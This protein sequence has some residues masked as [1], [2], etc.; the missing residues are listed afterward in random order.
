MDINVT[1]TAPDLSG[2]I[3]SLAD[4]IVAAG[5][6]PVHTGLLES[7][8]PNVA[9]IPQIELP[10]IPAL[11]TASAPVQN[12]AQPQQLMQP[13]ITPPVQI[14][15]QQFVQ[16]PVIPAQI[17]VQ[18]QPQQPP[19]TPPVVPTAPSTY[20]MEQLAVAATQLMD[21][22]RKNDLLNLLAQFNVQALTVLPKEQY[23]AFATQL[24]AMGAR[25]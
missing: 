22:G 8:I 13:P 23:G 5:C 18:L 6:I 3:Q 1:I 14:I 20:T 11:A 21:A 16:P 24:R 25:I 7:T 17:P 2:A 15:P 10:N 19:V 12:Y 9:L 4:A